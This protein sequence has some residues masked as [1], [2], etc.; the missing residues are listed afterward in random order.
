MNALTLKEIAA[1][2]KLS[3]ATVSRALNGK[4]G[5]SQETRELVLNWVSQQRYTP[6]RAAQ[7]LATARTF[8]VAFV[9]RRQLV[10]TSNPFYERIMMGIE[11]ELQ[12]HG[13]HLIL[14]TIDD[15]A[16]GI[17]KL[18][19]T[20]DRRRVDGLII[21]GCELSTPTMRTLVALGLPVVLAANRLRNGGVNAV[22]SANRH[23]GYAATRHLI[24]HG[25][26]QI[27]FLSGPP[28]WSPIRERAHG[29]QEALSE[30]G[31]TPRVI[32]R[33]D[34]EIETGYAAMVEAFQRF[35]EITAVFASSDP[36]AIGALR[37][38]REA[39]RRVPDDLALVGFD[40]I[41]WAEST[42]PPLTTVYIH[43]H[44]IGKLAAQR[45]MQLLLDEAQPPIEVEVDNELVIR[46]SCGCGA[47]SP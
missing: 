7:S 21:A 43:K 28:E 36:M 12:E 47:G 31:L 23:G 41:P 19:T 35:P 39:G 14:T 26:R 15:D 25:H 33:P 1:Q 24:E 38:A 2:L 32:T 29:Y 16:R 6:N 44:R 17:G 11:A 18:P 5:I 4:E 22:T 3:T 20:I 9:I 8:A 27:A 42:D 40:N 37:A 13:Y 45:M 30:A 34:L 46:R 10:G